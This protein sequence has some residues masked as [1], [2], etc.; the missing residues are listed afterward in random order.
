MGELHGGDQQKGSKQAGVPAPYLRW[1]KPA[2]QDKRLLRGVQPS[3][4]A[5]QEE[6]TPRP[7]FAN[8]K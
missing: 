8:H 3:W 1:A 6:R 5:E 7:V 4:T 2:L